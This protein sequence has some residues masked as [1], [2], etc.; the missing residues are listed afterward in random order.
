MQNWYINANYK[1]LVNTQLF[2]KFDIY[3]MKFTTAMPASFFQSYASDLFS[4]TADLDLMNYQ[5]NP[6]KIADAVESVS[7]RQFQVLDVTNQKRYKQIHITSHD[8]IYKFDA[9]DTVQNMFL[10]QIRKFD[11][12]NYIVPV[13]ISVDREYLDKNS[14]SLDLRNVLQ[15]EDN[16]TKI[17]ET[18]TTFRK[19]ILI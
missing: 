1:L 17:K 12:V 8:D 3:L 15:E 14:N 9:D 18:M 16:L 11:K 19:I 4:N 5:H 7:D 6:I 10:I 2:L 13:A